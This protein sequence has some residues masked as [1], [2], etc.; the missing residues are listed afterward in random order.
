MGEAEDGSTAWV[1]IPARGGSVGIPRK[2]L[3]RLGGKPLIRHVID[4]ARKV[5][6]PE[7]VVVVTDD[8][9]IDAVAKAAGVEVI[10]ETTPTPSAETLDTKI[11]RNL[12]ELRRRGARDTDPVVTVQ[13]TSPLLSADT[14][15]A[16][17]RAFGSTGVASVLTVAPD[18][19]L[20]WRLSESGSVVPA[21]TARVNRQQLPLE[22]R[23]TGGIIAARLGDIEATQTRIIEPVEVIVLDADEAVDIDSYADLL[24][25]A[26]LLSRM[27]VAIRVDASRELG[28]GHVYRMLALVSELA[29]H[30]I[31]V[32]LSASEP[33]GQRFFEGTPYRVE[34]VENEEAFHARLR[35]SLPELIVL[36]RLDTETA[37]IASIRAASPNSRIVTFEDCGG[38]AA[39]ADLLVAEFVDNPSVPQERKLTGI[40]YALLA[41]SF[42]S[43]EPAAKRVVAEVHNVLVLF[44][45]TDPSGLANR[46][47]GSLARVGYVGDVTVARGLGAGALD[48]NSNL[49]FAVQVLDNVKNMPALMSRADL[50]F[51]SAGRT[52]IELLSRGT[53]AICLAQNA[54]ELTHNHATEENG[55]LAL[56]L[57]AS[58]SDE[59]L[60]AAT[61]SMLDDLELRQSYADRAVRAGKQ[62]SNRKTLSAILARLGFEEL[63]VY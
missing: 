16:A 48:L 44:G 5:L 18:Q 28:M 57:G 63:S 14:L 40:D 4:T 36:D 34:L 1:V 45:G 52:V 10:L 38:G 8:V 6:P 29:R 55:V 41:P 50:A 54:K 19:H 20:R 11:V 33:L 31:T 58:V 13:P 21:F 15:S 61:R 26:H 23:E 27:R 25:A 30:D 39:E 37:E 35:A 7:H 43:G 46:A 22:Y 17:L 62:R 9:E 49:P 42:E 24:T 12:P 53:P 3:R 60:D 59:Q 2:N 47:L 51:T 32:Y 56:G